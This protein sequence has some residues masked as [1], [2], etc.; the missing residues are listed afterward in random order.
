MSFPPRA[1]AA[2]Q[3]PQQ[4]SHRKSWPRSA[5]ATLSWSRRR[6]GPG[7][8][9]SSRRWCSTIPS[10]QRPN[11]CECR[12]DHMFY[13]L[14]SFSHTISVLNVFQYITTRTGGAMFTAGIF[15]FLFGPTIINRL[16]LKQGKGQ[17]IR[18]DGP[19]SHLLTKKGT[20]TMG[21]LMILSGFVVSTLL[22]ANL[23][24]AYVW[25]DRKSTRLNSSHLG[26]SY[27]VFCL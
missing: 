27:A 4:S 7:W 11:R 25:V 21:G 26:I 13:W 12:A 2:M 1:A 20:P 19:Q 17:P 18:P 24:N 3:K 9:R 16:R 14:S 8:D 5:P 10:R 15:V 6:Q 23:G 22:W